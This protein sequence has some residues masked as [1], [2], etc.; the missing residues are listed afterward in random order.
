MRR[1]CSIGERK[2]SY[3]RQCRWTFLFVCL[4]RKISK[5]QD[6]SRRSIATRPSRLKMKGEEEAGVEQGAARV[7]MSRGKGRVHVNTTRVPTYPDA[8]G[9]AQLFCEGAGW[10]TSWFEPLRRG[11]RSPTFL[12]RPPHLP[13]RRVRSTARLYRWNKIY[14]FSRP[15]SCSPLARHVVAALW[16]LS[17]ALTWDSIIPGR[18][19]PH[20]LSYSLHIYFARP[21]SANPL[22]DRTSP[23][24]FPSWISS[25]HFTSPV[26]I[27]K[28]HGVIRSF[29]FMIAFTQHT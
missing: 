22:P 17:G 25:C 13:R 21:L 27:Y 5:D 14:S 7:C 11:S 3:R 19:S 6:F 24:Y 15:G 26:N 28:L 29:S 20:P 2:F 9:R 10:F 1:Q 8:R 18:T 12:L 23:M 16:F 4:P